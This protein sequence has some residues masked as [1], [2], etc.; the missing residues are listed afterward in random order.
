MQSTVV[1][2]FLMLIDTAARLRVPMCLADSNILFFVE[3]I[4][5]LNFITQ[6]SH[7]EIVK[8]RYI[9]PS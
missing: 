7:F 3:I 5:F 6:A 1:F 2:L 4:D 9:S 8:G